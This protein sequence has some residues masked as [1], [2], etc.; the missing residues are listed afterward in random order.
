MESSAMAAPSEFDQPSK[1][2]ILAI[3]GI[4]IMGLTLTLAFL[5]QRIPMAFYEAALQFGEIGAGVCF[6]PNA[7]RAMSLISLRVRRL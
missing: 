5:K 2:F 6:E 7:L 4:S 1:P 3:V